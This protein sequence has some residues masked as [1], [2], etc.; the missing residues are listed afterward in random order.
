[1]PDST[2][3]TEH[4][5]IYA[6]YIRVASTDSKKN[7]SLCIVKLSY[8]IRDPETKEL[9]YGLESNTSSLFHRFKC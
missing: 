5:N 7:P 9:R 2:P 8:L 1:M 4:A 3:R 6:L